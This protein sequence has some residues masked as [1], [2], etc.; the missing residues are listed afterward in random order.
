MNKLFGFIIILLFSVLLYSCGSVKKLNYFNNQVPGLQAIDSLKDSVLQR[1]HPGDR[2][3]V[4]FSCP[5]PELTAFLNPVNNSGENGFGY[6]VNNEGKVNL[7]LIGM[8]QVSGMTAEQ[9]AGEIQKKI[10][11]YYKDAFVTVSLYGRVVM[12][13]SRGGGIVPIV[14]GRLTI[15]EA[16]AQI[17]NQDIFDKRKEVWVVREESGERKFE[18]VDLT[19][20]E[21]FDSPYYY[22]HNNDLV[23]IGH[24]NMN[25][26]FGINSAPRG[27]IATGI[28]VL[29]LVIAITRLR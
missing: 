20:K 2:V 24:G 19:K 22:L 23:Y 1:I 21:I 4:L 12:L 14:N 29:A 9:A 3:S 18:K 28:S 27:L 11:Y 7:P 5:A 25:A 26:L 6:L 17:P 15:F 10:S 8:M 16:I 13:N